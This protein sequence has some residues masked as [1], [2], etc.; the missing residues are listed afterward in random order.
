MR[1]D[2]SSPEQVPGASSEK[3][4]P[5]DKAPPHRRLFLNQQRALS[6]LQRLYRIGGSIV[7]EG[8]IGVGKTLIAREAAKWLQ[9]VHPGLKTL[10]I[11]ADAWTNFEGGFQALAGKAKASF[12]SAPRFLRHDPYQESGR[13]RYV[14]EN[15]LPVGNM[16][17]MMEKVASI[18]DS[19]P[20]VSRDRSLAT[21]NVLARLLR[22]QV[23][24][25]R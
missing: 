22:D 12:G 19:A 20:H 14:Q 7:I 15:Q 16:I 4:T 1:K 2:S 18:Q 23:Q 21:L 3:A 13:R 10:E 11:H 17:Q 6:T 25:F 8:G 9:T 5:P 24:I